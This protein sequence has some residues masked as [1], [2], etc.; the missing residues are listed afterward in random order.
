MDTATQTK[1]LAEGV[2]GA[3]L[4]PNE[5]RKKM[6]LKPIAGGNTVYM[7]QQNWSLEQLDRRDIIEDGKNV[8]PPPA[9]D[10][11]PDP[12]PVEGEEEE[13][14][15]EETKSAIFAHYLKKELE[16]VKDC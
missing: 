4:T 3:I 11:P 9:E 14:L 8:A 13:E 15:D 16:C 12:P 7:Q 1:T 6:D 5:A 2:K 10:N